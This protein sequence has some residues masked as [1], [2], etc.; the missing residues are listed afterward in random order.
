MNC[1]KEAESKLREYDTR[2]QAL[3]SLKDQ[4]RTLEMEMNNVRSATT[5]GTAIRGGGNRR[6]NMLVNNIAEREELKRAYV[7]TESWLHAVEKALNTLEEEER[8]ILD[9]FYIRNQKGRV[10]RLC[11]KMHVEQAEVYRRKNAALKK[12]TYCFYGVT[13]T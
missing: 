2:K 5:D 12:F 9:L 13:E 10:E 8:Y 11:E 4:I 3:K 1:I 6:E 7:I